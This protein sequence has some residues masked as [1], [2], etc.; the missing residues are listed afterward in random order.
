MEDLNLTGVLHFDNDVLLFDDPE[1]IIGVASRLYSNVTVT[2]AFWAEIVFGMGYIPNAQALR[3]V[4]DSVAVE[5]NKGWPYL[6]Q[7]YSGY[8]HEMAI[9]NATA[10]LEFFPVLPEG[11][12]RYANHYDAFGCVF[13]PS[14]Y[15][16]YLS[17]YIHDNNPGYTAKYHEIGKHI[18]S[19]RLKVYMLDGIPVAEYD[20]RDIRIANLHIHSK[21]TEP[22]L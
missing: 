17:G 19:G 10:S 18:I 7:T 5:L 21:F 14:S 12:D 16:Q 15:G 3:E 13:D 1:R 9:M 8:P 4:N 22:Y 11:E 6:Y 20:G 2:S